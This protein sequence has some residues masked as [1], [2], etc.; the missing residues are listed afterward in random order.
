MVRNYSKKFFDCFTPFFKNYFLQ[1]L[2][3]EDTLHHL[4]GD[5][6]NTWML[7]KNKIFLYQGVP[8][9][10]LWFLPS[11]LTAFD[12]K[13]KFKLM[14]LTVNWKKDEGLEDWNVEHWI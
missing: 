2:K 8:L 7:I 11:R 14:R 12:P 1:V 10:I 5:V 13:R 4:V 6:C 9:M 3:S